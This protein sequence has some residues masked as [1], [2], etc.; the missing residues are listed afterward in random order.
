[1]PAI[2][3]DQYRVRFLHNGNV[4]SVTVWGKDAVRAVDDAERHLPALLKTTDTVSAVLISCE[5]VD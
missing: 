1:M 2:P 5:K 4:V 3:F